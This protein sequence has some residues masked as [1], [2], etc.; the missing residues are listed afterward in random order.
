MVN[1]RLGPEN[2]V[3]AKLT[4]ETGAGISSWQNKKAACA[5]GNERR[6]PSDRFDRSPGE[7][8]LFTEFDT[9]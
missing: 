9:Q 7:G 1:R 5:M 3:T 4:F 8:T 6:L 2:H